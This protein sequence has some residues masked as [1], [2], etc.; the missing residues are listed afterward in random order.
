MPP[1]TSNVHAWHVAI[2]TLW[3]AAWVGLGLL[4]SSLA[5]RSGHHAGRWRLAGAALG[6]L[7]VPVWILR[8]RRPLPKAEIVEVGWPPAASP[9]LLVVPTRG[10]TPEL[11]RAISD[12]RVHGGTIALARVIPFDSPP[13]DVDRERAHLRG[14]RAALGLPAAT[15]VLLR[16]DLTRAIVT[17]AQ[18]EQIPLALVDG[19]IHGVVGA[20]RILRPDDVHP[21]RRA[22]AV[23]ILASSEPIDLAASR[24]ARRAAVQRRAE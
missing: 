18:D 20:V 1:E 14:D 2:T 6:P 3:L 23:R 22:P 4:G 24:L 9:G 5:V 16:G 11:V 8:H 12:L 17:H 21:A 13:R 7:V 15:L 19:D 10:P